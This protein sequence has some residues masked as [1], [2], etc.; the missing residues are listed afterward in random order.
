MVTAITT[1][2]SKKLGDRE[3]TV[4]NL[5][6]V[7]LRL[8]LAVTNAAPN[9]DISFAWESVE[10][11]LDAPEGLPAPVREAMRQVTKSLDGR[12]GTA[13][14]TARGIHRDITHDTPP[15]EE[16]NVQGLFALITEFV[17]Q[18]S[19]PL[20]KE[21][22]GLGARWEVTTAKNH[23]EGIRLTQTV[24]YELE[25]LA[26][27]EARLRMYIAVSALSQDFEHPEIPTTASARLKRVHGDGEGEVVIDFD[28]LVAR[29]MQ[30]TVESRTELSVTEGEEEQDLSVTR[31]LRFETKRE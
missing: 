30:M 9:G 16:A 22:V 8:R 13:R 20:P 28:R 18:A 26:G 25:S 4:T 21:P 27:N 1:E 17:E 15:P 29:S 31:K 10:M 23:I 3:P 2:E 6:G 24:T 5:P 14:Q 19:I 11:T 12:S 7:S